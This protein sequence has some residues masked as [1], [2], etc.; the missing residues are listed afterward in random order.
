VTLVWLSWAGL[1]AQ[2]VYCWL[3]ARPSFEDRHRGKSIAEMSAPAH[4]VL[5]PAEQRFADEV[6]ALTVE[7]QATGEQPFVPIV[8]RKPRRLVN[9]NVGR[10]QRA[11]HVIEQRRTMAALERSLAFELDPLCAP[12]TGQ[13]AGASTYSSVRSL[14]PEAWRLESFTQGWSRSDLER[15]LEA[16]R[17]AGI[18]ASEREL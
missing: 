11:E 10:R 14:E 1:L 15:R 7:W 12:L 17:Q 5:K 4:D 6:H 3:R 8:R 18:E 9:R 13:L 2:R 16:V